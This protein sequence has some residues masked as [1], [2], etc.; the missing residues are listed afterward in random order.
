[1]KEIAI[2]ILR[3]FWSFIRW[4]KTLNFL[5]Y[6]LIILIARELTNLTT[7]LGPY[8]DYLI[9]KYPDLNDLLLD[10]LKL[11]SF[12]FSKGSW[13]TL[14]VYCLILIGVG[15][16]KYQEINSVKNKSLVVSLN[17]RIEKLENEKTGL[18]KSKEKEKRTFE[19]EKSRIIESLKRQGVSTDKLIREYDK[20]LNAILISYSSQNVP[21]QN[22]GNKKEK[23]LRDELLRYDIISLGGSDFLIP[24]NN[25]PEDLKTSEDLQKWFEEEILKGRYCKVKFLTLIDLK[26]K[27]FWK[28]Y[29]PYEQKRPMNFTIGEKL[30]IDQVFTINDINQIALGD[31]IKK[32]DI[33]WLA[34]T[35]LSAEQQSVLRRNQLGI[36]QAL[37]NPSLIDMSKDNFKPRLINVLNNYFES[38]VEEISTRIISEAKYWKNKLY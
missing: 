13:I 31:I 34:T 37:D 19:S 14:L 18:S 8:F 35:F 29:L 28:N 6:T 21:T 17:K 26:S 20:P 23:F 22:G 15:F 38:D 24:P 2:N 11:L 33:L 32:G 3:G 16:L 9:E 4:R 25:V 7:E 36:E 5:L 1:M 10:G 12:I 30:S 27:V